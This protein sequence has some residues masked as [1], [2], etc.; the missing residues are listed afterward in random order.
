MVS[1]P[2]GQAE[3]KLS[4]GSQ[5][6]D[7][8]IAYSLGKRRDEAFLENV[9]F[10]HGVYE[11]RWR[12]P[13]LESMGLALAEPD[14]PAEHQAWTSKL[15]E[16]DEEDDADL[17]SCIIQGLEAAMLESKGKLSHLFRFENRGVMG[18]LQPSEFLEGL[19]RLEIV[20]PGHVDC[21]DIIDAMRKIDP[22]FD[23]RV[24][25]PALRNAILKSKSLRRKAQA[26]RAEQDEDEGEEDAELMP[27][28]KHTPVAA[29]SVEKMDSICNSQRSF[30]KF[31]HQQRQLIAMMDKHLLE[32][33]RNSR[34]A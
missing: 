5:H 12:D 15:A 9:R 1:S 6:R 2:S 3:V 19:Q 33:Q 10:E 26:A 23:G 34:E 18:T 8:A 31:Q 32:K 7:R 22:D 30:A 29:V 25:L 14:M 11:G 28:G 27:Y 21:Q 13:M 4:R 20:E 17:A 16:Q 24:N